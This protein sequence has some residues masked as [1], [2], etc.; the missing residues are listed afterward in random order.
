MIGLPELLILDVGHGNCAILRDTMA[1]SV[2]DCGYDGLTLI[3]TLE[4]LGIDT[5]DHVLISHADIDHIGG[6]PRLIKA[7]PIHNIYMNPDARKVGKKWENILRTLE[8][9][10]RSGTQVHIGLTSSNSQKII[11][12]EVSIEILSPSASLAA[13]GSGGTYLEGQ[14]LDSNMMSIVIGLIHKSCHVALLPGDIDNFSLNNLL[15]RNKNI[16]AQILVFP[17]H[18]GNSRSSDDQEFARKL[19]DLVKPKLVLFSL[20]RSRYENPKEEIV[21]GVVTALPVAHIICTQLSCKCTHA[22]FSSDSNHLTNFPAKGNAD[23]SCCGGTICIKLD[24]DRTTYDPS[25]SLHRQ[26]VKSLS[27]S[28]TETASIQEYNEAMRINTQRVFGPLCLR[29]LA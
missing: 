7:F 9:A 23:N 1:V 16:E 13:S 17:H 27:A 22:F 10:E 5:I 6:L 28:L 21:R 26:F 29:Y 12:G 15:K 2:I 19:C 4:Q 14:S 20:D 18:G 11:S 3:E 24:G 25:L 8:S